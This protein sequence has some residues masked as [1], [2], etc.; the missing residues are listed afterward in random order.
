MWRIFNEVVKSYKD[1]QLIYRHSKRK[2]YLTNTNNAILE[3]M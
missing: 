1:L 3:H 2:Q